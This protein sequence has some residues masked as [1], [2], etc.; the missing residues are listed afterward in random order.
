MPVKVTRLES[1]DVSGGPT[2]SKRPK[3][4]GREVNPSKFEGFRPTP[5]AALTYSLAVARRLAP[6]RLGRLLVTVLAVAAGGCTSTTPPP[7]TATAAFCG[8]DGGTMVPGTITNL[9]YG[10]TL[11]VRLA[12]AFSAAGLTFSIQT[13]ANV[14][15]ALTFFGSLPGDSLLTGTYDET[16]GTGATTTV[17]EAATGGVTWTQVSASNTNVGAFSLVVTDAGPAVSVDGGTSWP[18]PQGSLG[19]VLVPVG[20]LTDAG[21]AVA[22]NTPGNVCACG[23]LCN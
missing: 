22:V 12:A 15:P 20:T 23:S 5:R 4:P 6:V 2:C 17:Q 7:L 16:N 21:I 14:Y 13:G 3:A 11:V 1:L 8:V 18:S 10:P 19:A 9:P